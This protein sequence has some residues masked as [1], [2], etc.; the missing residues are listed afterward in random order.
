MIGFSLTFGESKSHFIGNLHHAFFI[1]V[2]EE[3]IN[4]VVNL[5]GI[6][7]AIYQCMFAAITPALAIG[8]A[9][10]RGR[11]LPAI[12]FIF[13]WST[14]VYDPIACWTWNVEGWSAKMGGL[15]FAGGTPVHIAS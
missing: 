7:F 5:P 12:L 2:D 15:D 9:G 13:I 10:E 4:N 6:V 11:I 14:L 8:S 3:R 1:G